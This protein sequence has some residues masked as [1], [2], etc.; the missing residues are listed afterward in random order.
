VPYKDDRFEYGELSLAL[1]EARIFL[2]NDVQLA[3]PT[4]D[5]AVGGTLLDGWSD[6]HDRE[7]IKDKRN[8]YL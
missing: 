1:F 6:F 2:V 8:G 7:T 3:I 4:H 5:F